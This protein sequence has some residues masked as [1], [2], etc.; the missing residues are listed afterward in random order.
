MSHVT[1]DIAARLWNLCNVLK[2][3]GVIY[4][5]QV[6]ALTYSAPFSRALRSRVEYA[7]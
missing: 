6:T 3:D 1:S 5:Q 4:H 7:C 2:D